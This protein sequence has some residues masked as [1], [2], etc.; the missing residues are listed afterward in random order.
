MVESDPLLHDLSARFKADREASP[1]V[2][3]WFASLQRE[4]RQAARGQR[5]KLPV[6]ETF[7][8]TALV[9]EAY[10]KLREL[11][12]ERVR[13]PRHFVAMAA[14]AMRQ[15]LVDQ[16]R[17]RMAAKRGGGLEPPL[18]LEGLELPVP[19]VESLVELS[20]ALDRLESLQP[21]LAEVVQ[22]RFFAGLTDAEIADLIDIDERTVRR[23]WDK[24]RG[25]LFQLLKA[26]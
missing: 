12:P 11:D 20:D 17:D 24:A 5:Q 18:S 15:V 9:N 1:S 26:G 21:R 10:L 3:T 2:A 14:R 19:G 23:D 22:L 7:S 13:E 4:L 6:G 25:F 8:T 16:V